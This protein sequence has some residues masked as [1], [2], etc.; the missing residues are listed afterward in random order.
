MPASDSAANG[1]WRRRRALLSYFIGAA[2]LA[3]IALGLRGHVENEREHAR[4]ATCLSN[5]KSLALACLMYARDDD[6][7]LPIIVRARPDTWAIATM[8]YVKAPDVLWCLNDLR[9]DEWW[10]YVSLTGRSSHYGVGIIQER[11]KVLGVAT[12]YLMNPALSGARVQ[13]I[14]DPVNTVLLDEFPPNHKGYRIVAYADGH[15]AALKTVAEDR[16]R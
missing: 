10:Q 9:F 1:A 4:R 2:G 3:L 11:A 14:D 16:A 5:I 12:S 15:C 7:R 13:E 6:D 8:K